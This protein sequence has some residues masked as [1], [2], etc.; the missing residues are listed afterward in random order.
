MKLPIISSLSIAA[1]TATTLASLGAPASAITLGVDVI[2]NSP[3]MNGIG[4]MPIPHA[5]QTFEGDGKTYEFSVVVPE[6]LGSRGK[7]YSDFGFLSGVNPDGSGGT[8][9]SL[10]TEG[11]RA[12]DPGSGND[13]DWLGTCAISIS[14]DCTV[15]YTFEDGVNYQLGL[16]DRGFGGGASNFSGFAVT[17]K[18]SYTFNVETDQNYPSL[19]TEDYVESNPDKFLTVVEQ[20]AYFLGMED[21]MFKKDSENY[22][23]DYQDWVVKVTHE[24]VPEPGTVGALLGLGVIG[25]ISRRRQA[26]KR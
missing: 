22:Y 4:P 17:Q 15:K 8:F 23:Y 7:T 9:V 5:T 18:D 13:N 21:G 3:F 26:V 19:L 10:F 12:Y 1:A 14:E 25:F 6:G 16:L 2:D 11:L 20:G 24:S